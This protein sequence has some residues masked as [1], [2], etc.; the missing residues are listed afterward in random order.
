MYYNN[1]IDFSATYTV[2]P[3]DDN[4]V[5][6]IAT[7]QDGNSVVKQPVSKLQ[8]LA[9][10]QTMIAGLQAQKINADAQIA[11]LNNLSTLIE[12]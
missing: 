3:I 12:G 10:I 8:K 6:L 9:D 7:S 2:E 11:F 4:N 5:R 1:N